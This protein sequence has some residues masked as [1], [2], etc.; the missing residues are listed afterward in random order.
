MDNATRLEN[1]KRE[2]VSYDLDKIE[3]TPTFSV[4][5]IYDVDLSK[6]IINNLSK[7]FPK[8][9]I[10]VSICPVKNIGKSLEE[11]KCP[12]EIYAHCV[13]NKEMFKSSINPKVAA[14]IN[15]EEDYNLTDSAKEK[16]KP[17]LSDADLNAVEI[18]SMQNKKF[19]YKLLSI[20]LNPYLTLSSTIQIPEGNV[21][22]IME[23]K[24][25]SD[26]NIL[27]AIRSQKKPEKKKKQKR[28]R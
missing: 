17:F 27:L 23:V 3:F 4:Q 16:L 14:L 12:I 20:K 2:G 28:Q 10:S 7:R 26:K 19:K 15:V 18:R 24:H 8:M 13:L 9:I 21:F 1:E 25:Y 6:A 5:Y 11:G 22:D